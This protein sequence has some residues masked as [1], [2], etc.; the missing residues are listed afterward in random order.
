MKFPAHVLTVLLLA[1]LLSF[2][3]AAADQVRDYPLA[4]IAA[5][6]YVIHGPLGYPSPEN[7]GFMNNPGF[8]ITKDSVVVI[9]PGASL[10]VGRMLLKQIRTV[11]KLPVTHV[12][13]TH[14]HGDH[15]LGNQAI[16]EAFPGVKLM[17]HPEMIKKIKEGEG[18]VWVNMMN[19]LTKGYTKGTRSVPPETAT[20]DRSDIKIGGMTFRVHAPEKAHSHTDIMIEAVEE[21]VVFAGDN[22]LN[23]TIAR[24]V[25]GTFRGNIAACDRIAA[26]KAK[27]YVPGH[28][29]TGDVS[30]VTNYRNYLATVFDDVKQ[31]Y[32]LGK[33]D[34]EMKDGIV[35]KLEFF[36]GWDRFDIEV[37]KHISQAVLE[38]EAA[39]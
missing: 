25:D 33:S 14:V 12:F 30:V 39:M 28:G 15:W 38:I 23:Q 32:E 22:V 10:Q 35:A 7:Q 18:Q 13:N 27:H 16:R 9:D 5:H 34:F 4:K 6:T 2:S 8:V 21:S 11:T 37:G 31:Q 1:P 20:P 17:G 26:I 24:M 3:A 19:D 36:Q 29:P